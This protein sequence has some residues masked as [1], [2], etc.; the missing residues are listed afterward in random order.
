MNVC[1]YVC[2][3]VDE[4]Y[5]LAANMGGAGFVFSGEHDSEIMHNSA[6]INL[7][8]A[9]LAKQYKFRT[10]YSSSACV[11]PRHN[12]TD[13]DNP[14]C[15]ESTAY[16]ADPDSPY[17]FEK[18]FSERLYESY[19]RNHNLYVRVARFHNIMGTEGSWEGGREKAPAAICRKGATAKMT[20]NHRIEIWGDGNQTRSFCWIDDC[21]DGIIAVMN[22]NESAPVNLGSSE[23]VSINE[24]VSIAEE[25]SGIKLERSYL[26]DA[27]KG[28]NGRNSDNTEFKRRYGWEPSTPLRTGMELTYRWIERKVTESL[29]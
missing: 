18:L 3:R 17:G 2:D 6:Q 24:L 11:Y 4:V 1:E 29:A 25:I 20:G 9:E 16:P 8:I 10:F 26:L 28:V 22:G 19:A 27:P 23:M 12:Q 7:N 21:V 13:P 5:Q 14:N 15:E